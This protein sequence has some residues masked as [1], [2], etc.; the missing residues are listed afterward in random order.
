MV[1]FTIW[2]WWNLTES[3]P[4]FSGQAEDE[5]GTG[6]DS[7]FRGHLDSTAGAFEIVA[8]VD[9]LQGRVVA[10]F[11]AIFHYHQRTTFLSAFRAL[12]GAVSSAF[13]ER[14]LLQ[15]CEIVEFLLIYAVRSGAYDDSDDIRVRKRLSIKSLQPLK[16]SISV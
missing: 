10:G 9:A 16:G 11:D 15:G 12:S 13:A 2:S 1:P 14:S 3:L 6:P 8:A 7:S 4:G 5:M